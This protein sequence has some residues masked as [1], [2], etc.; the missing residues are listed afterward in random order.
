MSFWDGLNEDLQVALGG[1][2]AV[3]ALFGARDAAKNAELDKD[4]LKFN[5]ALDILNLDRFI[6]RQEAELKFVNRDIDISKGRETNLNLEAELAATRQGY[7]DLRAT[8]IRQHT[9]AEAQEMH[10]LANL[11]HDAARAGLDEAY[12]RNVVNV[13]KAA[14][15]EGARIES[16]RLALADMGVAERQVFDAREAELQVQGQ[17]V[18]AQAGQARRRIAASGR[19]LDEQLQSLISRTTAELQAV[20]SS[21]AVL[22]A[23]EQLAGARSNVARTRLFSAM[24]EATDAAAASEQAR[25]VTGSFGRQERSR[26]LAQRAQGEELID[27]ERQQALAQV[28]QGRFSA[29]AQAE[30]IRGSRTAGRARAS[31]QRALLREQRAGVDSSSALERARIAAGRSR[32]QRDRATL[33]ARERTTLSGLAAR[34]VAAEGAVRGAGA[35][36]TRIQAQRAQATG[37]QRQAIGASR[38]HRQ[39]GVLQ[40]AGETQSAAAQAVQRARTLQAA[41]EERTDRDRLWERRRDIEVGQRISEYTKTHLPG[42]P[43]I[44]PGAVY[45]NT[46]LGLGVAYD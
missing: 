7:H 22:D 24:Q 26:F 2:A 30:G 8:S 13:H 39:Q 40:A 3:A 25:G 6:K 29:R 33:G 28:E 19:L 14:A 36:E 21:F 17:L 44:T 45:V 23:S 1:A 11:R 9:S 27:L 32:L 12:V 35:A 43:V 20:S 5:R 42:L 38:R 37:E 41:R 46:L 4:T 18:G 10:D 16:E 31:E 15:A 34:Q